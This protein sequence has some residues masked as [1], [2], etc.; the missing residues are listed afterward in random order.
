MRV[1]VSA[2][3]CPCVR[4]PAARLPGAVLAFVAPQQPK[5]RLCTGFRNI[6]QRLFLVLPPLL[7][8]PPPPSWSPVQQMNCYCRA[9]RYVLVVALGQCWMPSWRIPKYLGGKII[10]REKF[11]RETSRAIQ[12]RVLQVDPAFTVLQV[13]C[14]QGTFDENQLSDVALVS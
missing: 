2:S 12:G 14:L 3:V 7:I 4:V 5:S 13:H 10:Q 11:K 8:S 1:R 9:C 6:F